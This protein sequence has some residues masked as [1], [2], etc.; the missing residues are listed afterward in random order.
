[1]LLVG[2]DLGNRDVGIAGLYRLLDGTNVLI[3]FGTAWRGLSDVV[4]V[5]L[6]EAASKDLLH[7][8]R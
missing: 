2:A 4:S 5:T 1:V 6:P 7:S 3:Q 8:F